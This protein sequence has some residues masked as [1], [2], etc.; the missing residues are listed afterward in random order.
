[1]SALNIVFLHSPI[2]RLPSKVALGLQGNEQ[3]YE[4]ALAC[5]RDPFRRVGK[6]Q[7]AHGCAIES[8]S[9]AKNEVK[10]L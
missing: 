6:A 8:R 2:N 9:A 4:C 3:D 10:D 7:R 5:A 1:M